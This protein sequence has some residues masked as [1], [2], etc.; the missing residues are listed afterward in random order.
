MWT[1]EDDHCVLWTRG[2]EWNASSLDVQ[3]KRD[4][5]IDKN[6]VTDLCISTFSSYHFY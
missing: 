5:G 1:L 3:H 4:M 2:D 6:L